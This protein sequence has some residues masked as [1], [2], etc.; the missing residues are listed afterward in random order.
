MKIQTLKVVA[1]SG[2]MALFLS[3]KLAFAENLIIQKAWIRAMPPGRTIT[4][5]YA[6]LINKGETAVAIN[7]VFVE[8]AAHAEIHKTEIR[9]EVTQMRRL[10]I[11][12]I[13]PDSRLDLRPGGIHLMIM[14]YD[15]R[16]MAG[17]SVDICLMLSNDREV[18]AEA[19]VEGR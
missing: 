9:N 15:D 16:I 6:S 4:A 14:G 8:G 7:G 10:A 2:I 1:A 11:L 13:A 12:E 17:K 3:V 5:G 18:C 19:S